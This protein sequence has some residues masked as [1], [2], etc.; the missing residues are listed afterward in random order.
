MLSSGTEW[1][2]MVP[3]DTLVTR[4]ATLRVSFFRSYHILTSSVIYY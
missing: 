3:S 1:C 2:R 4:S